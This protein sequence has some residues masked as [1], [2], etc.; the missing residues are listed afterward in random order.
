MGTTRVIVG[1][2]VSDRQN[3]RSTVAHVQQDARAAPPDRQTHATTNNY[4]GVYICLTSFST[5][6]LVKLFSGRSRRCRSGSGGWVAPRERMLLAKGSFALGL[7]AVSASCMPMHKLEKRMPTWVGTVPYSHLVNASWGY[8]TDC[9][10]F[11]SWTLEAGADV[12]AYEW[13]ASKYATPI[14]ADSLRYGDIITHV[15]DHT[16]LNR[17]ATADPE[18]EVDAEAE[19]DAANSSSTVELPSLYMSGHVMFFDRWDDDERSHFW[20]YESTEAADQTEECK[21]ETGWLT[22]PG[23]LNHHVKKK[24]TKTIDKWEKDQCHDSKYGKLTGGARRVVPRLLCQDHSSQ[25]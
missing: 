21:K 19:A 3:V 9:S 6:V 16:L 18:A 24:R 25:R 17:C 22:R 15:W 23:C 5:S 11:I 10:G 20:A 7:A 12:K 2:R 14:S 1:S 8:P 4:S 13:S